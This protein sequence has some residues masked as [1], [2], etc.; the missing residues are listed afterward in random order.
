MRPS[1]DRYYL[2]IAKEVAQRATCF[3]VRVGAIIVRNDQI[4]ATGYNGAPRKVRDCFE[5]GNCLKD[6][7]N[8]PSGQG[9]ELCRSVHAEQ[10]CFINSA[11]AGVSVLGGDMYLWGINGRN[12]EEIDTFPCFICKKMIINA[13]L[14]RAVCSIK[15]GGFKIFNISDWIKDWQ[16]KDILDDKHQYK[17]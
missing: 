13:G 8:V 1:K 10:N 15:D 3:R 6:K 11:R 12:N 9:Y 2:N 5:R 17:V 14:V 7:L 4:V 16:E